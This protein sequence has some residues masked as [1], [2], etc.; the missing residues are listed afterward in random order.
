MVLQGEGNTL[1]VVNPQ[2]KVN[3]CNYT[4]FNICLFN[5]N[6]AGFKTC[7]LVGIYHKGKVQCINFSCA[8]E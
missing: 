6:T 1:I 3:T 7:E 8:C 2:C 4:D 5:L